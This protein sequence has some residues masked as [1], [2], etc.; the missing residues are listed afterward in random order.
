[1]NFI[2]KVYRTVY[3]VILTGFL[4]SHPIAQTRVK[5]MSKRMNDSYLTGYTAWRMKKVYELYISLGY[6]I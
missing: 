2:F 4:P 5:H 1:M 3:F 6:K